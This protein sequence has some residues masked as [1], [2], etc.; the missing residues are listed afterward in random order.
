MSEAV[1]VALITGLLAVAAE[2]VI[3]VVNNKAMM[4]ELEKQSALSDARLEKTQAVTETK[5]EALTNE[6][7]SHNQ[8]AQRLPVIEEQMKVANHRISDLEAAVKQ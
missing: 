1:T 3:A 6:V 7:R 5:L 8:F 4:K 2:V